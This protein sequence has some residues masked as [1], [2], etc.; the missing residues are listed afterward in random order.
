MK[1]RRSHS[2]AKSGPVQRR[3]LTSKRFGQAL[4]RIAGWLERMEIKVSDPPCPPSCG[5]NQGCVLT[6][7]GTH[8]YDVKGI[9]R[10]GLPKHPAN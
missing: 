5:Q 2:V 9:A 7:I 6:H 1:D 4:K 3:A 8:V 10:G